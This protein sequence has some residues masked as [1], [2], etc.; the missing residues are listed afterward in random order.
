MRQKNLA[1]Q[2][3][4]WPIYGDFPSA[5]TAST[6]ILVLVQNLTSH[7]NSSHPGRIAFQDRSQLVASA[8]SVIGW[9]RPPVLILATSRGFAT[10]PCFPT[11][12]QSFQLHYTIFSDICDG[13]VWGCA[14]STLIHKF[15]TGNGFRDPGFLQDVHFACKVTLKGNLS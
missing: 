4:F 15:V 6:T 5:C 8:A 1:V 13:S 11:K 7:L 12:M 9:E 14:V 3:C 10:R 2:C